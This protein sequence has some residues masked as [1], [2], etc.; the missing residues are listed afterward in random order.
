MIKEY[1]NL[2]LIILGEGEE[3]KKLEKLT[4]NLGL[5]KILFF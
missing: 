4:K 5:K 1:P 2:K 3:R